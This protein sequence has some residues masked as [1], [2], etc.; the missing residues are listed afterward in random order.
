MQRNPKRERKKTH[1]DARVAAQRSTLRRRRAVRI[2]G[3]LGAL[4]VVGGL[5]VYAAANDATKPKARAA[6]TPTPSATPPPCPRVP[7]P[8][9]S[10]RQYDTAPSTSILEPGADY[11]ATVKTSCGSFEIDLREDDAPQAVANFVFLAQE[12]YFNGLPWHRIERNFVIQTGD[13]NGRNGEEPDGPGY[14]IPD[15]LE[16]VRSKDYVMGAV[17][18][19]NAGPNTAGSQ[20]FVIVRSDGE[21][22]GL[23]PLYTIFGRVPDRF[24]DTLDEI[25]QQPVKGG[26][27]PATAAEPEVP[28]YIE[29]VDISAAA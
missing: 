19:A 25:S 14:T 22:A 17:G 21:P 29:S 23:D 28:V 10:P 11:S 20:W 1:R 12:G 18:M 26:T 3:V 8:E 5:M 7:V 6:G 4:A 27:D 16:G 13:P 15:E 24:F 2:A 9:S